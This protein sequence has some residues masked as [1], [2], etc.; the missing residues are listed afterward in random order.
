MTAELHALPASDRDDPRWIYDRYHSRV[1]R[2][3]LRR[4]GPRDAEDIAAETLARCYAHADRIDLG[5]DLWPWLCTVAHNVGCD[6]ARG[7]LR[8]VAVPDE[9]L[10]SLR[11][12][13][14][15]DASEEVITRDEWRMLRQAFGGLSPADRL[16]LRMREVEELGFDAIGDFLGMTANTARQRVFRA[17]NRLGKLYGELDTRV[18]AILVVL[19]A[20]RGWLR[21]RAAASSART[22]EYA[23]LLASPVAYCLTW[24]ATVAIGTGMLGIAV[25]GGR[26]DGP[27]PRATTA[28]TAAWS[29]RD[30]G[31]PGH[32]G[33][34]RPARAGDQDPLGGDTRHVEADVGPARVRSKVRDPGK[35][36]EDGETDR[37][38][39]EVP[40][41]FGVLGVETWGTNPPSDDTGVVCYVTGYCPP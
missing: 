5:R 2:F 15:L 23:S 31:E 24:A 36:N 32:G 35:I 10:E 26:T 13:A 14:A 30:A 37:T 28:L 12:D 33:T 16:I 22:Q 8:D 19:V 1:F 29:P 9:T 18:R 21:R 3:A 4:F 6:I 25:P 38:R 27:A 11:G 40:T 17:R 41:P 20:G 7:R 34:R 39:I